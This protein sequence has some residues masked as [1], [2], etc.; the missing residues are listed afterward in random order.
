MRTHIPHICCALATVGTLA[1][2]GC[3]GE[4]RLSKTE[5][6]QKVRAEYAHVLD[7]FRATGTAFGKPGLAD[8]ITRAQA[9]LR[10]AAD[11][12]AGA[13]APADVEK[14]NEE[15]VEGMREYADDLDQLRDAAEQGDLRAIEGFNDRIAK[16]EAVEQIAEAA[17]EMK[18]KGYDLGQIAEE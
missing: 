8:K 10:E 1:L 17:E 3:G 15:I 18:F 5:Y 4:Q 9:Q 7:A 2:A 16:N 11:A 6:E 12:L 13:E 14:E